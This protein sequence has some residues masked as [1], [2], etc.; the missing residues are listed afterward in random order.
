AEWVG[1]PLVCDPLL[2]WSRV[3]RT[4][5]R[6]API[7]RPGKPWPGI[8]ETLPIEFHDNLLHEP[9]FQTKD[10]TFCIWRLSGSNSWSCGAMALPTMPDADVSEALLSSLSGHVQDYVRFARDYYEVE[11]SAQDVAAVYRHVRLTETLVR[12]LNPKADLEGL[13]KDMAQIGYPELT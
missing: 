9:A 13:S 7:F 3:K 6:G 10:S 1:R 11:L 5:A 2:G 8:F 4:F 12:R